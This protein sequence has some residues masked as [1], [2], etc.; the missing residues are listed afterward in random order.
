MAFENPISDFITYYNGRATD[1][2][3]W[4]VTY[5]C[6]EKSPYPLYIAGVVGVVVL[7][8]ALRVCRWYQDK[9]AK[10]LEKGDYSNEDSAAAFYAD[11]NGVNRNV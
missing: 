6:P 11:G 7:C 10:E 9:K 3:S 1:Q 4:G 5:L 8:I 2:T